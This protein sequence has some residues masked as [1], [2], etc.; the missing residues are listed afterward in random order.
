M[1]LL[2]GDVHCQFEFINTQFRHA[3]QRF[4]AAPTTVLQLGD[5]GFYKKRL[6]E[7]FEEQENT[8]AAHVHFIDGNHEDFLRL[9]SLKKRFAAHFTHHPR[10]SNQEFLGMRFGMLGGASFMD[11]INTP[12]GSVISRGDVERCM[13]MEPGAIEVVVSHDC[14]TGI[15]VPGRAAFGYCG[16]PGFTGSRS[17]LKRH[18]PKLWF[19]AHHHDWFRADDGRTKFYGLA[20]AWEGYGILQQDGTYTEVR[21]KIAEEAFASQ[22]CP[23]PLKIP[24]LERRKERAGHR[25]SLLEKLL[26]KAGLKH[27]PSMKKADCTATTSN[28]KE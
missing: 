11:H 15:G 4:G 28:P 17:I 22:P 23:R 16:E 10:C 18:A 13:R 25:L 19:F 7:F 27:A 24:F 3:T 14:P 5:M 2:L 12:A 6:I 8:L 21:H 20:P 26:H 1:L 9:D